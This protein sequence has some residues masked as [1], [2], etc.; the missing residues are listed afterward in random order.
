LQLNEFAIEDLRGIFERLGAE[1]WHAI[2]IGGQAV[3][4]WTMRFAGQVEALGSYRPFTSRDLDFYGGRVEAKRMIEILQ[5]SGKLNDG[6]DP[7]PNAAVLQVRLSAGRTLVIDILTGAYG[8]SSSELIRTSVAWVPTESGLACEVHVI[9][10]LLLLESKLAC[11]RSLSQHGRQDEKHLRMM[12]SVIHGWLAEQSNQPRSA[13]KAIER[14][15]AQM[16]TPDGLNAYVKGLDLWAAIPLIN[17]KSNP[18]FEVFF[19]RRLPQL[20]REVEER[21]SQY[22]ESLSN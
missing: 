3:N 18:L 2:L 12:M 13:F 16:L 21:R 1:N 10:P 7:S 15:V 9:H 17:W 8:V 11:L 22:R 19:Q 4:L 5:A 20:Q 6:S 14:I